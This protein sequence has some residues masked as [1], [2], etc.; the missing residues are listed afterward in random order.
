MFALLL[1]KTIVYSQEMI[2]RRVGFDVNAEH[3]YEQNYSENDE[4]E[5]IEKSEPLK[6]HRR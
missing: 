2:D 6:L 5:T 3:E 1:S 4:I